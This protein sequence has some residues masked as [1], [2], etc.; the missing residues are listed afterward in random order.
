MKN[1]NLHIYNQQAAKMLSKLGYKD[2]DDSMDSA[3][4]LASAFGVKII[5]RTGPANEL[6]KRS[7]MTTVNNEKERYEIGVVLWKQ[8]DIPWRVIYQDGGNIMA[9]STDIGP[10][11][12]QCEM[13]AL[14]RQEND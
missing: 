3:K 6:D 1:K 8:D 2:Q 5:V 11:L 13:R 4:I 14:S 7:W 10:V 9:E 12:K